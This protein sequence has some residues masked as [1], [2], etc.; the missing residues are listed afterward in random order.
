MVK[1]TKYLILTM[2]TLSMVLC[3]CSSEEQSMMTLNSRNSDF[4]VDS[5]L[6]VY[7]SQEMNVQLYFYNVLTSLE[8]RTYPESSTEKARE[9]GKIFST[10][11]LED[12]N[13]LLTRSNTGDWE[14]DKPDIYDVL[15]DNLSIEDCIAIDN[16]IVEYLI[17]E[18]EKR[19]ELLQQTISEGSNEFKI[20]CVKIAATYDSGIF[21]FIEG[22]INDEVTYH[23]WVTSHK[24][25]LEMAAALGS[26]VIVELAISGLTEGTL[27]ISSTDCMVDIVEATATYLGCKL[28]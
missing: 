17:S 11:S 2:L 7:L 15:S 22:Y 6:S 28:I 4:T 8:A 23:Q 14:R 25:A 24:C 16:F 13:Y 12:L 21:P 20:S 26:A 10:L 19:N 18:E 9:A 3:G 1:R 27:T 5:I